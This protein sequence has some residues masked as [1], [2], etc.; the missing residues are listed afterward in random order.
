MPNPEVVERIV[1]GI[2]AS[3]VC[4]GLLVAL[5]TGRMVNLANMLSTFSRRDRPRYFWY[6]IALVAGLALFCAYLAIFPPP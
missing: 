5:K 4:L 3:L 2:L 6:N 1:A